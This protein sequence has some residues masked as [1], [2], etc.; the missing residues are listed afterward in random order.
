MTQNISLNGRIIHKFDGQ[1]FIDSFV[2]H[3]F[4]CNA[5][6]PILA[7]DNHYVHCENCPTSYDLLKHRPV[8][9]S[10]QRVIAK[11]R[12]DGTIARRYVNYS[13]QLCLFGGVE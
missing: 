6:L 10:E 4:E 7:D 9:P 8:H 13:G 1:R 3:C 2:H 12:P 11:P 5:L